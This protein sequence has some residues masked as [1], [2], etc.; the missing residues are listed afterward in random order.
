VTD[1]PVYLDAAGVAK[2]YLLR[3]RRTAR[4]RMREAGA[5]NN[6]GGRLLVSI[7]NLDAWDASHELPRP[8]ADA[9]SPAARVRH[10]ASRPTFE[11]L[12]P[13]WWKDTTT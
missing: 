8:A 9:A 13:D 1:P 3:D 5:I 12:E 11:P 10:R 7:T 6:G 4:R 2:R